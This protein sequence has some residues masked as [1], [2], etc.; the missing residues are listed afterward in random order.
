[1]NSLRMNVNT[2][3]LTFPEKQKAKRNDVDERSR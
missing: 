1:M 3:F 2:L